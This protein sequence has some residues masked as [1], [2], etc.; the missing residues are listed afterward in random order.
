MSHTRRIRFRH[1]C[2]LKPKRTLLSSL[3]SSR[4][5]S[6]IFTVTNILAI[7]RWGLCADEFPATDHFPPALYVREARSIDCLKLALDS[8]VRSYFYAFG[9]DLRQYAPLATFLGA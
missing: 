6:L 9:L 7:V 8:M 3:A 1:T 2:T 5:R 4:T